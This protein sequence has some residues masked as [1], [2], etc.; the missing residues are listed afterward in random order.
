MTTLAVIVAGADNRPPM[1]DKNMYNSWKSRMEL[2]I[3]GKEN[4]IIILNL[5]NNGPLI[6]PTVE[7]NGVTRVKRYEELFVAEKLK[8]DCDLKATNIIFQGTTLLKQERECK[9]YDE[10]DKFSYVKGETLHQYYLR[11][12]PIDCINKAMA[13]LSVVASRFSSTNNQLRTSS[14]LR[15]QATIQDGS[16][17]NNATGQGKVVKCYNRQGEGHMARQCTQPKRKRDSV[18][19]KEKVLLVQAHDDGKELDEEQLAFLADLGVAD[20][21]V[22]QTITHNATF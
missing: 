18:W 2:Y 19:F 14:N 20:G 22:A 9:L 15:N 4:G 5:V 21:Q 13:V 11:E 1:L 7:E 16:G 12:D 10:F 3:E 8:A 17:R 6:W